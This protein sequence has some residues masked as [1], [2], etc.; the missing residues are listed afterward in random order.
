MRKLKA[1]KKV[2]AVAL[3]ALLGATMAGSF[4][5]CGKSKVSDTAVDLEIFYWNSGTGEEWLNKSIEKFVEKYPECNVIKNYSADNTTWANDLTSP[6]T[7]TIDLFISSMT[8]FLAYTDYLEPMDDVLDVDLDGNGVKLIDKQDK[9][10]LDTQRGQD[11]KLY[12]TMWG[13]GICGIV[14]NKTLFEQNGYEVPRTTDELADLS[15]DIVDD[16]MTPFMHCSNADYW[17]YAILPWWGQYGGVEE[18]MNFWNARY[19]DEEGNVSELDVRSM[20]EYEGKWK[21]LE[22]LE[23]CISPLNHTWAASNDTR[24]TDVQ[25]W[26]LDGKALMTPNGS[27]LEN[28]MKSTPTDY[29]FVMMKAP[30]ISALGEKLGISSDKDLA[31][32]VSYVDS[33]DYAN[34]VINDDSE[35]YSATRVKKYDDAI[36]ARVAEARRVTYTESASGRMIIPNYATGKEYAKKFVQYLQTD[37]ALAI[38][39]ETV[40]IPSLVKPT[41]DMVDTSNWSLFEKSCME[42]SQNGDYVFRAKGHPLFYMTSN[43]SEPYP[44]MTQ[45]Y[46]TA[47]NEEDKLTAEQLRTKFTSWYIENWED[48]LVQAGL[49]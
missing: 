10:I 12:A 17:M 4:S 7:N 24:H 31:E 32:I 36:I 42:V 47:R 30:I 2:T 35:E 37:E 41:V 33:E 44:E 40:H 27:W 48:A 18:V 5:A 9:S 6:S 38:Y 3:T 14:Y 39:T 19:V 13:G 1:I 45:T 28:E 29:E 16:G 26:F 11:G 22:A 8:N 34:G 43:F 21:A 46:L 23:K 49:S 25:T 20:Y 15:D